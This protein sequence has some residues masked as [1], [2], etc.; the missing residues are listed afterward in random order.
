MAVIFLGV[1]NMII[2]NASLSLPFLSVYVQGGS[3]DG[4]PPSLRSLATP[5]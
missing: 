2:N 4:L 3:C 1:K 5:N